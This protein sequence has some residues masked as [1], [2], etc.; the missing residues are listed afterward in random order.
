M[1]IIVSTTKI[2]VFGGLIL[3][4]SMSCVS[5]NSKFNIA[6][7]LAVQKNPDKKIVIELEMNKETISDVVPIFAEWLDFNYTI[8]RGQNNYK[9]ISI[10]LEGE[11]SIKELWEKLNKVME[12]AQAKYTLID[13]RLRIYP[14][15]YNNLND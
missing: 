1:K 12:V 2:L 6:T 4:F 11:Y 3:I 15:N 9:K 5:T 8:F 10:K 7:P 13:N 14:K